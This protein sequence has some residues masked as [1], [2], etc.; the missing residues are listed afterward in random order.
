M[1]MKLIATLAHDVPEQDAPLSSIDPTFE[2][3]RQNS[4]S[5]RKLVISVRAA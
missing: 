5:L 1:L 4:E 2:R 3:R